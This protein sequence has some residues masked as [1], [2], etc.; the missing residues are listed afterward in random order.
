MQLATVE[1]ELALD[2][3]HR[4]GIEGQDAIT[5]LDQILRKAPTHSLAEWVTV[6]ADADPRSLARYYGNDACRD[7]RALAIHLKPSRA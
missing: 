6:H 4:A 2:T 1:R 3:L 5:S 7:A